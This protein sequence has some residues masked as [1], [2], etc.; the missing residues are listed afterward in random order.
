MEG[1]VAGEYQTNGKKSFARQFFSSLGNFQRI[2]LFDII[3]L[4]L[5]GNHYENVEPRNNDTIIWQNIR[6]YPPAIIFVLYS[7]FSISNIIQFMH[8]IKT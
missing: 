8:L 5:F 1:K 3:A 7:I 2:F 6:N 4:L